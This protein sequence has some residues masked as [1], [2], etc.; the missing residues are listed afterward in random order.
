MNIFKRVCYQGMFKSHSGS[1][2]SIKWEKVSTE[3]VALNTCELSNETKK[4]VY[5]HDKEIHMLTCELGKYPT[6]AT[7]PINF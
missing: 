3:T 2:W 7:Y 6:S 1:L 4:I 5:A